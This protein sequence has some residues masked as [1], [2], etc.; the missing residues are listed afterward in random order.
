MPSR[1][2]LGHGQY[3]IPLQSNASLHASPAPPLLVVDPP[4]VDVPLNPLELLEP[5]DDEPLDDDDDDVELDVEPPGPSPFTVVVHAT[6]GR[7]SATTTDFMTD[8]LPC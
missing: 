2:P 6:S 7:A 1:P 8:R 4:E 5:P 3:G